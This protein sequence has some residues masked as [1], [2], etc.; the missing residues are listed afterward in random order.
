MSST[1]GHSSPPPAQFNS[2]YFPGPSS[3]YNHTRPRPSA[4]H[5]RPKSSYTPIGP[6]LSTEKRAHRRAHTQKSSISSVPSPPTSEYS[7][8]PLS[9]FSSYSANMAAAQSAAQM[10]HTPAKSSR[11]SSS[12]QNSPF[13]DYFTDEARSIDSNI[14][15]TETKQLLVRM[16]KL[17]SQLMRDNSES[18]RDAI[19]IVGRK[20]NEIELELNALHSQSRLPLEIEDSGVFMDEEQY[21][22]AKDEATPIGQRVS[23][24]YLHAPNAGVDVESEPVTIEQYKAERD[25]FIVRMQ[26][27]IED[28]GKAQV[29]LGKRYAE[30]RELNEYHNAQIEDRDTQIEQLRS[31]NEGLRSD[32]GFEHSELLFLKLQ[33]KSLEV[34]V[35]TLAGDDLTTSATEAQRAKSAKKNRI[36]SEM[37]GWR[38]DW[39]DVDARFKRR[40]SRYGVSLDRR[41][42]MSMSDAVSNH[43]EGDWHLETVKEG[44]GRVTSLTIKRMGS[45]GGPQGDVTAEEATPTRDEAGANPSQGLDGQTNTTTTTTSQG[46]GEPQIATPLS[47]PQHTTY[48][49]HGTQT[50][51]PLPLQFSLIPTSQDDEEEAQTPQP[52][53]TLFPE[54]E[55]E[56]QDEDADEEEAEDCAITT[57]SE[58]SDQDD[59]EETIIDVEDSR[60]DTLSLDADE[61][62]NSVKPRTAWQE[63]WS[64]LAN[65][66]GLPD[67]DDE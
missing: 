57:S 52:S 50:E 31:E 62:S 51:F 22:G 13:S 32:L 49:E 3:R 18:G 29:E 30:V 20:L 10:P 64:S 43:D 12:L 67:D 26:D 42:S 33:M 39:Q 58:E 55:D 40:R 4:H 14:S 46:P 21:G 1:S 25:W 34:E 16:N 47:S 6:V 54:H 66:S 17:Q 5:S 41:D 27:L 2:F 8:S 23:E 53:H 37:D 36:L 60:K 48:Q 59:E 7:R 11:R 65:L 24:P 15:S 44:R 38:S 61:P 45:S 56:E 63:L 9:R 19:N 35:D 28:L